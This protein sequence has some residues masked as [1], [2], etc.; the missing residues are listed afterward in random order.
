[1]SVRSRRARARTTGGSGS[2]AA[3]CATPSTTTTRTGSCR[4]AAA[5]GRTT[6]P[7]APGRGTAPPPRRKLCARVKELELWKNR[8]ML[9]CGSSGRAPHLTGIYHLTMTNQINK[10][11]F[12]VWL[13][14]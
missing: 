7:A 8:N 12:C 14:T 13:V 10:T 3:G 2:T 5:G 11:V 6:R 9:Q 4:T 1:M